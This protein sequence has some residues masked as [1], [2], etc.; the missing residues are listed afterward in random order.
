MMNLASLSFLV[1][2]LAW[3]LSSL[4]TTSAYSFGAG[5][6]SGGMPAVGAPHLP[7]GGISTTFKNGTLEQGSITVLLDGQPLTP[8]VAASF[9]VGQSHTLTLQR[10]TGYKGLLFRLPVGTTALSPQTGDTNLQV[11]MVCTQLSVSGV[12][13][14]SN[15]VKTQSSMDFQVNSAASTM[16]LDVTVVISNNGASEFYYSPFILNATPAPVV[17]TVS[18]TVAPIAPTEAP[19]APTEA[20]VAPTEA[21]VAPTL[22]P[23]A[24]T[25]APVT[26]VAQTAAPSASTPAPSQAPVAPIVAPVV[27]TAT[28]SSAPFASPITSPKTPSVA[29]IAPMAVPVTPATAPIIFSTNS[30]PTLSPTFSPSLAP[31]KKPASHTRSNIWSE[32][33]ACASHTA[34]T[35]PYKRCSEPKAS[36]RSQ[37]RKGW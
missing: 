14:T 24:P 17:S 23:V 35:R 31:S 20:P 4:Q 22:A 30:V 27:T 10:S 34:E 29:P 1:V 2:F 32:T 3:S 21:P 15:N 36:R 11:A 13:H 18:P 26:P 9:V 6:C 7:G 8:G 25:N 33:S 37:N 5:G 16:P 28:P 19:F 12:T